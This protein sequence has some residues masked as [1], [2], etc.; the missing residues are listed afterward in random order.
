MSHKSV[1]LYICII[2]V[3]LQCKAK[4][5]KTLIKLVKNYSVIVH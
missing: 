1:K 2:Y 4:C 5:P 3:G